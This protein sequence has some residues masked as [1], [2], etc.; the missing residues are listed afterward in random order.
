M[1]LK[2]KNLSKEFGII[3]IIIIIVAFLGW[4]FWPNIRKLILGSDYQEVTVPR[5]L[6]TVD[7]ILKQEVL[8]QLEKLKQYGEWPISAVRDNPDRGD[9]F[10][11]KQ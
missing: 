8:S 7:R 10:T 1:N 11:P 3:L 4:W 5:S 6:T 2:N 9:P